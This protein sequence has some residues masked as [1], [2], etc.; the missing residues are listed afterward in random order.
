L[1]DQTKSFTEMNREK[2]LQATDNKTEQS[3][4]VHNSQRK[5]S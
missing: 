5:D 1:Q 3:R 2:L 4:T